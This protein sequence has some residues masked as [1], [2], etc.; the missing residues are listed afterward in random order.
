MVKNKLP[1]FMVHCV[2]LKISMREFFF[3]NY[4]GSL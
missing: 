2:H 1:C 4:Y 3:K